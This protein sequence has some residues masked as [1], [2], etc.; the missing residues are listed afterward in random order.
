VRHPNEI[1]IEYPSF[2]HADALRGAMD[3]M[4]QRIV[5]KH[6]DRLW[7]IRRVTPDY[8]RD[9]RVYITMVPYDGPAKWGDRAPATAV[10][11]EGCERDRLSDYLQAQCRY[12]AEAGWTCDPLCEQWTPPNS[13]VVYSTAKALETQTAIDWLAIDRR[14]A[15]R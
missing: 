12:L 13:T 15:G 5:C 8:G 7:L 11:Y 1:T 2:S 14:E 6:E 4:R 9:G 3:T 10:A